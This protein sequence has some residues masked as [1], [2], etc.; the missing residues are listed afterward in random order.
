MI[1]HGPTN[2]VTLWG[3]IVKSS[4][5]EI[6]PLPFQIY[7]SRT[8]SFGVTAKQQK[9]KRLTLKVKENSYIYYFIYLLLAFIYRSHLQTPR[10]GRHV[11]ECGA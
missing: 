2:R 6:N 8:N 7:S 9:F 1:I 3:V 5:L 4:E 10:S 11:R